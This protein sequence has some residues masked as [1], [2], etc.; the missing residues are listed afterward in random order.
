L[1]ERDQRIELLEVSSTPREGHER[2]E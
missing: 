2:R 1:E